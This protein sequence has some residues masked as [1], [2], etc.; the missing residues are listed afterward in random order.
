MIIVKTNGKKIEYV[1]KEYR[2]KMSNVGTHREL[3]KRKR[4]KKKSAKRREEIQKA[5][6][7]S[8]NEGK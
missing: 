7:K 6:Y 3:N 5:I 8:K 2:Q 4:F 1:L